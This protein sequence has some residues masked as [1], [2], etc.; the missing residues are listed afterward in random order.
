MKTV[1]NCA[2]TNYRHVVKLTTTN[3]LDLSLT[4]GLA[5]AHYLTCGFDVSSPSASEPFLRSGGRDLDLPNLPS[6]LSEMINHQYHCVFVHIPKTAGKSINRFFGMEWQKHKDLSRYANELE[7]QV[8]ARYFKFAIVR[9]PWDRLLSDYNFQKKKNAP[10]N[11]KLFAV[12]DRGQSRRFRDWVETALFKPDHYEP[13]R[14]G[15]EVSPG[16]HRWSPQVDWISLDGKIAVDC[17]L[18]LERLQKDFEKVCRVLGRPSGELPCRNW[19]FHLHYS[20]YYDE[21]TQRLVGDYYAKDIEAFG[22]RF[23]ARKTDLRWVMLEKLATRWK[24][25]ARNALDGCGDGSLSK[26]SFAGE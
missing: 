19:K 3:L 16:I 25:V 21:A 14:W 4:F 26:E 10:A 20:H 7:P 18:R 13:R 9:N 17:V 22:Y 2:G 1:P 8:F 12:D 5:E 15:A 24:S 6:Q 11:Q 23:E